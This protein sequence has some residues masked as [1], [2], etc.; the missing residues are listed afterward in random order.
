[1]VKEMIHLAHTGKAVMAKKYHKSN[2]VVMIPLTISA[3]LVEMTPP[4]VFNGSSEIVFRRSNFFS[5]DIFI[6]AISL[7]FREKN[8]DSKKA[9]KDSKINDTSAT[10]TAAT[11][12]AQLQNSGV[13]ILSQRDV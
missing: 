7:L 3:Y 4:N 1:M 5:L 12:I 11:T 6:S 10:T 8:S 9:V 2:D 13:L